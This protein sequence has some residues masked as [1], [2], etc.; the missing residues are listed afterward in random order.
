M[1]QYKYRF[2]FFLV[3]MLILIIIGPWTLNSNSVGKTSLL[4]EES[5]VGYY[6]TN[7]CEFSGGGVLKE[8]F[9][10]NEIQFLPDLNSKIKCHGRINGVDYSPDKIKVYI[11]TNLNLDFLIQ[12]LT[13]ILFLSLIP[14]TQKE[15]LDFLEKLFL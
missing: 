1:I 8:N 11:G 4:I 10:N 6:Q 2:Q 7:T 15:V 9:F 12:S 14:K 5:S 13:W 3:A